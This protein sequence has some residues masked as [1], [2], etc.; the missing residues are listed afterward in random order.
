MIKPGIVDKF[1]HSPTIT[2]YEVVQ[3]SNNVHSI[4]NCNLVMHRDIFQVTWVHFCYFIGFW[5]ETLN[6]DGPQLPQYQQNEQPHLTSN[7]WI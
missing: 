3:W 2:I 5:Q 4:E 1:D 7:N 6:S